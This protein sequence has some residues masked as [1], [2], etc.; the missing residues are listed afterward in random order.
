[1]NILFAVGLLTC[2]YMVHYEYPA[3]LDEPAVMGWVMRDT[4]AAKAGVQV[5]DRIVASTASQN[6]TWEQV[7]PREALNPNQPLDVTLDRNGQLID[8]TIVP[9]A[10]RRFADGFRG[11]DPKQTDCP[12]HRS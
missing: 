12:H 10:Y 4:P 1:M 6:P 8:K 9:E 7:I 5:G 3:V 11:W 2:V